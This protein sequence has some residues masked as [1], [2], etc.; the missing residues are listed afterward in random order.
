MYI[1]MN[2]FSTQ[3]IN[4]SK[5]NTNLM[6]QGRN[7]RV[8][9][10]G[11]WSGMGMAATL[12]RDILSSRGIFQ[13]DPRHSNDIL[14]TFCSHMRFCFGITQHI[15]I[16]LSKLRAMTLAE[17]DDFSNGKNVHVSPK[18]DVCSKTKTERYSNQSQVRDIVR[19]LV[20]SLLPKVPQDSS[21][22]MASGLD[23][24]GM[25]LDSVRNIMLRLQSNLRVY[26]FLRYHTAC[27]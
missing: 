8:V 3:I 17:D 23:S 26:F 5:R 12:D 9:N 27:E 16:Q 1:S 15:Y 10:W 13:F 11:P 18:P 20:S 4:S 22:L 24:L 7:H 21:P 14:Q 19:K 2:I 25:L 6:L